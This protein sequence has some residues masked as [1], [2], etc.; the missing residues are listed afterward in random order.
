L[1]G[2]LAADDGAL[3]LTVTASTPRPVRLQFAELPPPAALHDALE[4]RIPGERYYDDIHGAPA[5]RRQMTLQF[6]E[7]IRAELAGNGAA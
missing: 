3:M 6:A 1:I 5:W 4:A 7:E 2:T